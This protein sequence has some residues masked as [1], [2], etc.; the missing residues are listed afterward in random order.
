MKILKITKTGLFYKVKF[1]DDTVYKFH[2]SIII[3]YKFI[4]KNIDVSPSK[5]QKAIKDNEYHLALDKGVRYLS[6]VKSKSEVVLYLKRH[7]EEDVISKAIDKLIE[8]KLI[9]DKECAVVYADIMKKKGYGIKKIF[10]ELKELQIDDEYI[11][12]A[13][14]NY[15]S[16]DGLENCRKAFNKY[17]SSVKKGSKLGAKTKITNH[18][19]S[20]GFT[21]EEIQVVINENQN[22]F[23]E[24]I[25]EDKALIDTYNKLLKTKKQNCDEKKFKNKVIRS[26]LQKGFPIY[27]ILKV[28]ESGYE[29]D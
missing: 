13:L 26:L 16:N 9:D 18:L 22:L 20:K 12:E 2:E 29:D 25:D 19:I 28:I 6:T 24:K 5:L 7:F 11:N 8:L 17:F 1:D 15:T 14:M 27:K 4:K 23:D 3:D 21:N 10:N